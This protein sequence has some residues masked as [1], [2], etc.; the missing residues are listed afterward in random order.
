MPLASVMS[1]AELLPQILSQYI[2]VTVQNFE[3]LLILFLSLPVLKLAHQTR[4]RYILFAFP[5][6]I[7]L[8][9][10]SSTLRRLKI[11][12]GCDYCSRGFYLLPPHPRFSC[13]CRSKHISVLQRYSIFMVCYSIIPCFAVLSGVNND[14]F[15]VLYS[16]YVCQSVIHLLIVSISPLGWWHRFICSIL[17]VLPVFCYVNVFNSLSYLIMY[18]ISVPIVSLVIRSIIQRIDAYTEVMEYT[19]FNHS[20]L[21]L[22]MSVFRALAPSEF[23]YRMMP[24]YSQQTYKHRLSSKRQRFLERYTLRALSNFPSAKSIES[25]PSLHTLGPSSTPNL[26]AQTLYARSSPSLHSHTD[27]FDAH[28]SFHSH[29]FVEPEHHQLHRKSMSNFK[30]P[31]QA[32]NRGSLVAKDRQ[33][34]RIPLKPRGSSVFPYPLCLLPLP[35]KSV[36][37]ETS[38]DQGVLYSVV[39]APT[40]NTDLSPT[41]QEFGG[42]WINPEILKKRNPIVKYEV[43][44]H[45]HERYILLCMIHVQR[46]VMSMLNSKTVYTLSDELNYLGVLNL[47]FSTLDFIL[48][49]FFSSKSCLHKLKVDTK[50]YYV[51]VDLSSHASTMFKEQIEP[52]YPVDVEVVNSNITKS[53]GACLQTILTFA[54]MASYF[55]KS[56]GLE[57]TSIVVYTRTVLGFFGFGHHT[58]EMVNPGLSLLNGILSNFYEIASNVS[59]TPELL[60]TPMR[61]PTNT[62][63]PKAHALADF[64]TSESDSDISVVLAACSSQVSAPVRPKTTKA[65]NSM[66]RP[67]IPRPHNTHAS[68]KQ[69][70]HRVKST[71]R[72]GSMRFKNREKKKQLIN[73]DNRIFFINQVTGYN[74]IFSTRDFFTDIPRDIFISELIATD[75]FTHLLQSHSMAGNPYHSIYELLPPCYNLL[76]LPY[77][78]CRSTQGLVRGAR[79]DIICEDS[80]FFEVL[81]RP[82]LAYILMKLLIYTLAYDIRTTQP[83][84]VEEVLNTANYNSLCANSKASCFADISLSVLQDP[85]LL[86]FMSLESYQQN[87]ATLYNEIIERQ[88]TEPSRS[89]TPLDFQ[90]QTT[91]YARDPVFSRLFPIAPESVFLPDVLLSSPS[92]YP[93]V[94]AK[95]LPSIGFLAPYTRT[96]MRKIITQGITRNMGTNHDNRDAIDDRSDNQLLLPIGNLKGA[97]S[98]YGSCLNEDSAL[99]MLQVSSDPSIDI[100][101]RKPATMRTNANLSKR[102]TLADV[103]SEANSSFYDNKSTKNSGKRPVSPLRGNTSRISLTKFPSLT[104]T[105]RNVGNLLHMKPLQMLP[106]SRA[107]WRSSTVDIDSHLHLFGDQPIEM[108]VYDSEDSSSFTQFQGIRYSTARHHNAFSDILKRL[109]DFQTLEHICDIEFGPLNEDYLMFYGTARHFNNISQF[110]GR[111]S[112]HEYYKSILKAHTI[113][114]ESIA[115]YHEELYDSLFLLFPEA[116]SIIP[117]DIL[118]MNSKSVTRQA[119]R[120]AKGLLLNRKSQ[121]LEILSNQLSDSAKSEQKAN[122]HLSETTTVTSEETLPADADI[123]DLLGQEQIVS[124]CK[125]HR[126]KPSSHTPALFK[127]SSG[128]SKLLHS[129]AKNN[130]MKDIPHSTTTGDFTTLNT[131][132]YNPRYLDKPVS[133]ANLSSS[134][135]QLL[136]T[137]V[138]SPRHDVSK[139]SNDHPHSELTTLSPVPDIYGRDVV[140]REV[141]LLS[142]VAP[143]EGALSDLCYSND[144]SMNASGLNEVSAINESC[145]ALSVLLSAEIIEDT[146]STATKSNADD[147]TT[148]YAQSVDLVQLTMSTPTIATQSFNQPSDLSPSTA[149]DSLSVSSSTLSI[150]NSSLIR[151]CETPEDNPSN[152]ISRLISSPLG[153]PVL[154]NSTCC[155]TICSSERLMDSMYETSNLTSQTTNLVQEANIALLNTYQRTDDSAAHTTSTTCSCNIMHIATSAE[156]S[157]SSSSDG[158][159][160]GRRYT[161]S[162][163]SDDDIGSVVA[164]MDLSLV[165]DVIFRST[166][167][168]DSDTCTQMDFQTEACYSRD[169]HESSGYSPFIHIKSFTKKHNDDTQNSTDLTP[170]SIENSLEAQALAN[171]PDHL[172]CQ[173]H[174][175][176]AECVINARAS[177]SFHN[178]PGNVSEEVNTH[179]VSFTRQMLRLPV[180]LLKLILSAWYFPMKRLLKANNFIFKRQ[181]SISEE[182]EPYS[183]GKGNKPAKTSSPRMESNPS[184]QLSRP[185]FDSI[186]YINRLF[187]TLQSTAMLLP[188]FSFILY[189]GTKECTFLFRLMGPN[190]SMPSVLFQANILLFLIQLLVLKVNV[191]HNDIFSWAHEHVPNLAPISFSVLKETLYTPLKSIIAVLLKVVISLTDSLSLKLQWESLRK[192]CASMHTIAERVLYPRLPQGSEQAYFWILFNFFTGKAM[193]ISALRSIY[194]LIF[195]PTVYLIFLYYDKHAEKCQTR[196]M[197]FPLELFL[198]GLLIFANTYYIELLVNVQAIQ[199]VRLFMIINV[200]KGELE[201]MKSNSLTTA[202]TALQLFCI[203]NSLTMHGILTKTI[204]D[205]FLVLLSVMTYW[206]ILSSVVTVPPLLLSINSTVIFTCSFFMKLFVFKV[207]PYIMILQVVLC[208]FIFKYVRPF[209]ISYVLIMKAKVGI[210]LN[211]YQSQ[212]IFQFVISD[213]MFALLVKSLRMHENLSILKDRDGKINNEMAKNMGL[214]YYTLPNDSAESSISRAPAIYKRYKRLPTN[215][216]GFIIQTH[217]SIGESVTDSTALLFDNSTGNRIVSHR[218][219][220]CRLRDFIC[221]AFTGKIL[222]S[223][224]LYAYGIGLLSELRDPLQEHT[225]ICSNSARDGD[226]SYLASSPLSHQTSENRHNIPIIADTN[227][228][229][230]DELNHWRMYN[231]AYFYDSTLK[232]SSHSSV[233]SASCQPTNSCVTHEDLRN[234]WNHK[235]KNPRQSHSELKNVFAATNEFVRGYTSYNDNRTLGMRRYAEVS[236]NS[237]CMVISFS[238]LFL[239]ST[240]AECYKPADPSDKLTDNLDES[241]DDPGYLSSLT[242]PFRTQTNDAFYCSSIPFQIVREF[243]EILFLYISR[244]GK[245][246]VVTSASFYR[247]EIHTRC[248]SS[249][250]SDEMMNNILS[251]MNTTQLNLRSIFKSAKIMLPV[252][253]RTL[254][255]RYLRKLYA[256]D[257]SFP[258]QSSSSSVNVL[259]GKHHQAFDSNI[260]AISESMTVSMEESIAGMFGNEVNA[261]DFAHMD[262]KYTKEDLCTA[263]CLCDI[264]ALGEYMRD[265]FVKRVKRVLPRAYISIG[266]AH[267]LCIETVLG[268]YGCPFCVHGAAVS[269]ARYIAECVQPNGIGISD[270]ADRIHMKLKAV[271]ERLINY[272][273][274]DLDKMKERFAG[275]NA[276]VASIM[277]AHNLVAAYSRTCMKESYGYSVGE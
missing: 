18:L 260:G 171:A 238:D 169:L 209:L 14:E 63:Q 133:R 165:D 92:N 31:S 197:I 158:D 88:D 15:A 170:L 16:V 142:S 50:A 243:M 225:T 47:L 9:C 44:V 67:A 273:S 253:M 210:L 235:R 90:E 223:A 217:A 227:R 64:M 200:C 105:A 162:I 248:D 145:S 247:I 108:Q 185:I 56:M 109:T 27:C 236:P 99:K 143:S 89:G 195:L 249:S 73:T 112:A 80:C 144:E 179:S 125:K 36:D 98:I 153:Y 242:F 222:Q 74:D 224:K 256:K 276:T 97:R 71:P 257:K 2:L 62:E 233:R 58:F 19:T 198:Y 82:E 119:S 161:K 237:I 4:V 83:Y 199:V 60:Q 46:P 41:L 138:T 61:V 32:A 267:G 275:K 29:I 218:Y 42:D 11:L 22:V 203:E 201:L 202:Y 75:K 6:I 91:S 173:G 155:E 219:L 13:S 259:L 25:I 94:S 172:D 24:S 78:L 213:H 17:S 3:I 270:A 168:Y 130:L 246:I 254:N 181:L 268:N 176:S 87:A 160:G 250:L 206:F 8:I 129:K 186:P 96:A 68:I 103:A 150:H 215:N 151:T 101:I 40:L 116:T 69:Q 55:A 70:K 212:R 37:T 239:T 240:S 120:S 277:S 180:Q 167:I 86:N 214:R 163:E 241:S 178:L 207:A 194:I 251:Y 262:V 184:K 85:M 110:S 205:F 28:T 252:A 21:R 166:S 156:S 76:P 231:A 35:F 265:Y 221:E 204:L 182:V 123:A 100:T 159:S 134:S 51:Y 113:S 269:S 191:Q 107:R 49:N 33:G 187:E 93:L 137:N 72:P 232:V 131:Q 175:A 149:D 114:K 54:T 140:I 164:I 245:H 57:C 132:I 53:K 255:N 244:F 84:P 95:T 177:T 188:V 39:P 193:S 136:A 135:S 226:A 38:H 261:N 121:S 228:H 272:D 81:P 174:V 26:H 189:K 141:H 274:Y 115:R 234:Y 122:I 146:Q 66:A 258:S 126:R 106:L 12:N 271:L 127:M 43:N 7:S 65:I 59:S 102:S 77:K 208:L 117:R 263:I 79:H 128:P 104:F 148:E 1:S 118:L 216:C 111:M 152:N 230:S 20:L 34:D 154:T 48:S 190:F 264:L 30:Q 266:I 147:T 45:I 23:L 52:V 192:I 124:H 157:L 211:W 229:I 10:C 183:G 139:H 196:N 5:Q 220:L